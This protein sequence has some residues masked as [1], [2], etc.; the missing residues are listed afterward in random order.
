MALSVIPRFAN[1][2]AKYR[3]SDSI[4]ALADPIATHGNNPPVRLPRPVS[5][6][7]DSSTF[8]QHLPRFSRID[9]EPFNLRIEC[10]IQLFQRDIRRRI[11]EMDSFRSGVTHKDI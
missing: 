1:A 7:D 5:D 3:T 8:A 11:E 6:G 9:K 10:G 2:T 4:A